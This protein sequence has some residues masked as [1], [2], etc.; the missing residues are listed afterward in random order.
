MKYLFL[1]LAIVGEVVGSLATRQSWGF[2]KFVPSAIAVVGVMGAYYAFSLALK[3]GMHI[4]VAYGIWS[5]LGITLLTLIGVY[6][7]KE[8]LSMVQIAGIVLIV[9]GVLALELGK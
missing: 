9:G 4:G 2:T 5:A 7:F 8:P 1:L 3:N 6:V